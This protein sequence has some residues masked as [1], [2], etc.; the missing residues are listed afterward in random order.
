MIR[1]LLTLGLLAAL[2]AACM[3][4][5][6]SPE[7]PTPTPLAAP[8][9]VAPSATA[10]PLAFCPKMRSD[11]R[12][13]GVA[14]TLRVETSFGTIRIKLSTGQPLAAGN[15]YDLARCGFYDGVVI[16][17][18]VPDF[19]VQ[20]GD[21]QHGRRGALNL[22]LLGTGGPGYT[23]SDEPLVEEYRRGS[24]AL[25]RSTEPESQGSQF[26]FLIGD[27][28]SRASLQAAATYAIVGEV[29]E[30]MAVLEAIARLPQSGSPLNRPEDP[31]AVYIIEIIDEGAALP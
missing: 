29:I 30:G 27:E 17:R 25:A 22:P 12:P 18:I 24:V 21:G 31:E 26:F 1:R 15:F 6:P 28:R 10:D 4:P 19:I 13:L 2:P 20:S 7:L 8:I 16:H 3:P 14:T 9:V 5:Y 11:V 23:I